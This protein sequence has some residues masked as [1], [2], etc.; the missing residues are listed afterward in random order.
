MDRPEV[1]MLADDLENI[2]KLTGDNIV[3]KF[4]GISSSHQLPGP[5]FLTKL[6][7][8]QQETVYRCC[9]LLYTVTNGKKVP[10]KFQ[11]EA[12]LTVLTGQDSLIHSATGSG[13]TVHGPTR[14]S[15]T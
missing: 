7:I 13:K 10:R 5:D 1:S 2:R 4:E 6:S 14:A 15:G 11:L 9:L 12:S 3:S 8:S